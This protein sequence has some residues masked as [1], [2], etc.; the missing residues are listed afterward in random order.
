MKLDHMLSFRAYRASFMGVS[1]VAMSLRI[2]KFTAHST[3]YVRCVLPSDCSP[4]ACLF[5]CLLPVL[6]AYFSLWEW[7]FPH[8]GFLAA[9][10]DQLNNARRCCVKGTWNTIGNRNSS[11][12]EFWE[13]SSCLPIIRLSNIPLAFGAFLRYNRF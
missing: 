11:L 5:C 7:I 1:R 13:D 4:V 9:L 2:P 8:V 10:F 12:T 6:P 3:Q